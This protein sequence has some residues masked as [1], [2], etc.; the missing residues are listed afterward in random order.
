M[1]STIK[2]TLCTPCHPAVHAHPTALQKRMQL[3]Q[4]QPDAAAAATA[5][6]KQPVA[7]PSC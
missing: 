1:G 4:A 7:R 5:A 2:R 6:V 3:L